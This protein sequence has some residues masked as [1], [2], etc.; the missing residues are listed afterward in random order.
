MRVGKRVLGGA[1]A[2]ATAVTFSGTLLGGFAPV[3]AAVTPDTT[4][5]YDVVRVETGKPDTTVFGNLT[6]TEPKANGYATAYPCNQPRPLAS[7]VNYVAGQTVANFLGVRTDS[8][9]D[10]CVYTMA[11]THIIFDQSSDTKSVVATQPVRKKDT[12]DWG[13]TPA[14]GTVTKIQTGAANSTVLGNLTVTQPQAGGYVTAYP[15]DQPRP[16]ASNVNFVAGQTVANF[17]A[18]KTDSSGFFCVY[19]FTPSHII[20]DQIA[21]GADPDAVAPVRK[22]DTRSSGVTV[23]PD[24]PL[25]VHTGAVNATVFGNLTVTEP[26]AGGYVTAYPCDQVRPLASNVNFVAG[27]TVANFLG[28]RTDSNGDFCVF[29][30]VPSHIIFDQV[31]SSTQVNTVTPWRNVDTRIAGVS[32]MTAFSVEGDGVLSGGAQHYVAGAENVSVSEGLPPPS[33]SA[34]TVQAYVHAQ[35]PAFNE[36][37]RVVFKPAPGQI[38]TEGTTYSNIT[39]T[40]SGYYGGL[41]MS[42]SAVPP[43]SA[44]SGSFEVTQLVRDYSGRLVR[45][46]AKFKE[47]CNVQPYVTTGEVVYDSTM[48]PPTPPLGYTP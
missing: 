46:A 35:Y 31:G 2:V 20:F 41:E 40:P 21:S 26:Q 17:L 3:S 38:L 7:N 47:S 48:R 32:K 25:V 11:R 28:V 14:A 19:H 34:I 13:P 39:A 10:F 45:F 27:Q 4:F 29:S 12:R 36:M 33:D 9:G 18:V 44:F 1:A 5:A 8:N 6:I 23:K 22:V 30:N 15:C 24:S 43:C 42:N 16:T 37:W